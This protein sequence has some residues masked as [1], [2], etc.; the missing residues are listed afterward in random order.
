MIKRIVVPKWNNFI[1]TA[2]INHVYLILMM[3]KIVSKPHNT[4]V[5]EIIP[6]RQKQ[7]KTL[8]Q[9]RCGTSK[10]PSEGQVRQLFT[11]LE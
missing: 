8:G 10:R 6:A 3:S 7:R 1:T 4:H 5:L 9:Y 2:V 11:T